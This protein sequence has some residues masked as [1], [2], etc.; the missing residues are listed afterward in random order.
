MSAWGEKRGFM[1]NKR[2]LGSNY[3]HKAVEYLSKKG[4][5]ILECNYRTRS[6]EIDIVAKDGECICFVEVKFRTTNMY[7]NP[8]EAVDNRKQKQ[9]RKIASIYLMKHG[10]TEWTPCRFDVIAFAG[11]NLTHIENAF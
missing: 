10:L 3:E 7:G 11:E 9:I 8:L 2:K 1:D 6:G 4:Y 5:L